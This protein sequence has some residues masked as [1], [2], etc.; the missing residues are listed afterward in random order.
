MLSVCQSNV[1]AFRAVVESNRVKSLKKY[2]FGTL[3]SL[4]HEHNTFM[5]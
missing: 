3:Y 2:K 4:T 1:A 5:H